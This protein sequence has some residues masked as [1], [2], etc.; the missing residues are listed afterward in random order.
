MRKTVGEKHQQWQVKNTN[1]GKGAN[2]DSGN[3]MEHL[4]VFSI[5]K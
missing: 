4:L 3:F 5:N 1:S 2:G